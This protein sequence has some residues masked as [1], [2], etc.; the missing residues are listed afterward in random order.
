MNIL[1]TSS[2]IESLVSAILEAID[3]ADYEWPQEKNF[4]VAMWAKRLAMMRISPEEARQAILQ[5]LASQDT[6]PSIMDVL[7]CAL[8]PDWRTKYVSHSV[9]TVGLGK[10]FDVSGLKVVYPVI[11]KGTKNFT[12]M[13]LF[14]VP[15]SDID[16][17]AKKLFGEFSSRSRIEEFAKSHL[18]NIDKVKLADAMLLERYP[19][20][21]NYDWGNLP[22]L[23][24]PNTICPII[25]LR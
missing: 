23:G 1:G 13:N 20:V 22:E 12:R 9:A 19:D 15:L 2:N 24:K 10:I 16:E 5:C 11:F 17:D 25:S 4:M 8:G 14:M 18:I 3:D 6:P 7:E 21:W